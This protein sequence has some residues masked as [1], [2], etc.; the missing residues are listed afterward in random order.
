MGVLHKKTVLYKYPGTE[1]YTKRPPT[2]THRYPGRGDDTQRHPHT[3]T[4]E[5]G[6]TQKTPPPTHTDPGR[7]EGVSHNKTPHPHKYPDG[8]CYIKVSH[9]TQIRR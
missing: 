7:G 6:V 3:D 1:C 8:G 4:Q 9:P 5:G 2:H